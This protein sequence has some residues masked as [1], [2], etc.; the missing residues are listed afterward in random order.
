MNEKLAGKIAIYL[1]EDKEDRLTYVKVEYFI[2]MLL[3]E[4][5]KFIIIFVLFWV[6]GYVKNILTIFLVILLNVI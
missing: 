1:V 2:E 5:Q 4:L 6:L 3:S